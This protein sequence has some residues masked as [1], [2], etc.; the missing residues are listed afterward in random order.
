MV[1]E[2]AEQQKHISLLND[3]ISKYK[4]KIREL[5]DNN[6]SLLM[7]IEDR[8]DD[9]VIQNYFNVDVFQHKYYELAKLHQASQEQALKFQ[10]NMASIRHSSGI[11]LSNIY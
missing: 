5:S 9:N 1:N 6:S 8:E 4:Q 7:N 3:Q 2:K 10:L 11:F